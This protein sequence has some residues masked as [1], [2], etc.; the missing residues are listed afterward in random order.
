MKSMIVFVVRGVLTLFAV[1]AAHAEEFKVFESKKY[2]Y[3]MKI[4]AEFKMD[5]KEDKTT[6]WTFQPGSAPSEA[7]PAESKEGKKKAQQAQPKPQP[8]FVGPRGYQT[9]K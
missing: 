2:G 4:P 9:P 3:S 8:E 1:T 5:G 6:T 7:A